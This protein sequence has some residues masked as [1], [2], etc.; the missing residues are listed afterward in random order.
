[1]QIQSVQAVDALV[2]HNGHAV[3]D[4]GCSACTSSPANY[5]T[6]GRRQCPCCTSA[7]VGNV[8]RLGTSVGARARTCGG[9]PSGVRTANPNP[10]DT[11]DHNAARL[12]QAKAWHQGRPWRLMAGTT[13]S[14]SGQGP[15]SNTSGSDTGSA[16]PSTMPWPATNGHHGWLVRS[17]LVGAAASTAPAAAPSGGC[18]WALVCCV[19]R[20]LRY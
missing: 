4:C 16:P 7:M 20:S 17:M 8:G 12:A 18:R 1:M 15:D 3:T 11:A 14:F 9:R 2:F 10:A 19:H 13:G 5:A 6:C